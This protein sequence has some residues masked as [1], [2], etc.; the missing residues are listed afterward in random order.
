MLQ[1]SHPLPVAVRYDLARPCGV[2]NFPA[3]CLPLCSQ[4]PC[5]KEIALRCDTHQLR[6]LIVDFLNRP[7]PALRA[8]NL[9]LFDTASER[10]PSLN[11]PYLI[12][13]ELFALTTPALRS[14]TLHNCLLPWTSPILR[15]LTHL[16]IVLS[17]FAVPD[18]LRPSID[19]LLVVLNN[20]PNLHTLILS[21]L[22]CHITS[23]HEQD[24][25][26]KA[27]V[28]LPQLTR[29]ELSGKATVCA[30][31]LERLSISRMTKICLRTSSDNTGEEYL[32]A[33]SRI[34]ASTG[35]AIG[36]A[37]HNPF[38]ALS[39]DIHDF[40]L[41]ARLWISDPSHEEPFGELE[42]Q[43]GAGL[44]YKGHKCMLEVA[45]RWPTLQSTDYFSVLSSMTHQLRLDDTE[46][47]VM[48][49]VASQSSPQQ[50]I[51]AFNGMRDLRTLYV[52]EGH[53][54]TVLEALNPQ[55]L[56]NSADDGA[57][58]DLDNAFRVSG[59]RDEDGFLEADQV[60]TTRPQLLFPKLTAV[61]FG[62]TDLLVPS[63]NQDHRET[64]GERVWRNILHAA[65]C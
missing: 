22:P 65:Q 31:L 12:P 16:E 33:F 4:L 37:R 18:V 42:S 8:L 1:R 61:W 11:R 45:F 28:S 3:V 63:T 51:E 50:W 49:R 60:S 14:I 39:F 25:S 20:N 47:L 23:S 54:H 30:A 6:A 21:C 36:A 35:Y 48:Q 27:L 9:S 5:V 34:I 32:E 56:A 29:I 52:H 58:Q 24:L 62:P 43:A 15:G 19:Q 38:H 10:S 46:T 44:L 41:T 53:V 40:F 64:T 59:G 57:E 7:A 26:P 2:A 13:S 55:P 17:V